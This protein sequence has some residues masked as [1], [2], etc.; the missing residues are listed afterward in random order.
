MEGGG[1]QSRLLGRLLGRLRGDH[2]KY[3]LD[4]RYSL[5]SVSSPLYNQVEVL[6]PYQHKRV[7]SSRRKLTAHT[8]VSTS[9]IDLKSV[10]YVHI[11]PSTNEALHVSSMSESTGCSTN[12][13]DEDLEPQVCNRA[14]PNAS[15]AIDDD[16]FAAN[17][18]LRYGGQYL[19]PE[20]LPEFCDQ[21]H[22]LVEVI[23]NIQ[24][25]AKVTGE[26]P[27]ELE[28]RLEQEAREVSALAAEARNARDVVVRARAQ[29]RAVRA[30]RKH[31]VSH[32]ANLR[33]SEIRELEST[34][35][36]SD[37]KL[38]KSWEALK[39]AAEAAAFEPLLDEIK[40][41]QTALECL[42]RLVES[43]RSALSRAAAPSPTPLPPPENHEN[44]D[45]GA[46]GA[47]GGSG[48]RKRHEGARRAGGK[49]RRREPRS[50]PLSGEPSR[51][52]PPPQV[53]LYIQGTESTSRYRVGSAGAVAL[54]PLELPS[55][56]SVRDI[57]FFTTN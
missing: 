50:V 31:I 26:Y 1:R 10:Y 48:G 22:H 46:T 37:R 55:G 12:N 11:K 4:K 35:R 41:K 16:Q 14:S 7:R 51:H 44:D 52:A 3:N 39:E 25:Y 8:N 19:T 2:H 21:L 54:T 5:T 20:Q 34:V 47:S 49:R 36:L 18:D 28:R 24:S 29:R 45:S 53:T 23:R 32:L 6:H 57:L 9:P 27:S 30:H 56:G 42:V 33:E 13:E 15:S 43:R 38:F 40:S 17:I